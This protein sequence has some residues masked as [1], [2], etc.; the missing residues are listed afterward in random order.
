VDDP[1]RHWQTFGDIDTWPAQWASEVLPIAQK[2]ITDLE[3]GEPTSRTEN[4]SGLKCSWPVSIDRDYTKWANQQALNQLGKAGF[5]LAALL[6][7][8]FETR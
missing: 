8:I 5:R 1:P 2:A 4:N 3:I 7:A 6:H